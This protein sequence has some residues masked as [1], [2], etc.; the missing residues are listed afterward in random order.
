MARARASVRGEGGR[1]GESLDHRQFL[2][3]LAFSGRLKPI[4]PTGH[5]DVQSTTHTCSEKFGSRYARYD[6]EWMWPFT[7]VFVYEC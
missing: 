6:E 2:W 3:L 4:S 1:E 7:S 5:L